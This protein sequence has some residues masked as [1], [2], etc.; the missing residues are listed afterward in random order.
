M[1]N[2]SN[3]LHLSQSYEAGFLLGMKMCL[4]GMKK[5]Y[6]ILKT[7]YLYKI[8]INLFSIQFHFSLLR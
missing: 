3:K 5:M 4:K 1:A 8:Y 2:K 7:T 6:F